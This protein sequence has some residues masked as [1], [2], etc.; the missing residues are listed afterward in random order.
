MH[1]WL[2]RVHGAAAS[3]TRPGTS[4]DSRSVEG[5][6]LAEGD[7]ASGRVAI[8]ATRK[9]VQC[10][11]GPEASVNRRR[12]FENGAA[13]VAT[14]VPAIEGRAVKTA[15]S[16]EDQVGRGETPVGATLKA[17]EHGLRPLAFRRWSELEDGATLGAAKAYFAAGGPIEIAGRIQGHSRAR[18]DAIAAALENV[19]GRVT[20]FVPR[21]DRWL[22]PEDRT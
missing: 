16:I 8:S 19:Q 12:E 4:I 18:P 3:K 15:G 9:R 5:A 7:A 1:L 21:L 14:R 17:I 20:P 2:N 6:V 10:G 13:L 11:F 22:E